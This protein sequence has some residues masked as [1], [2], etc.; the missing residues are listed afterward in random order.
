MCHLCFVLFCHDLCTRALLRVSWWN[1]FVEVPGAWWCWSNSWYEASFC[2]IDCH[3]C[4]TALRERMSECLM[5][6]QVWMR[7][8]VPVIKK[9]SVAVSTTNVTL[10][11]LFG[12]HIICGISKSARNGKWTLCYLQAQ[13]GV[14]EGRGETFLPVSFSSCRELE[15]VLW[16][17]YFV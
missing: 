7:C 2:C 5:P 3:E 13:L 6:T 11:L 4:C 1:R 16:K 12:E 10:L 8:F 14:A 15:F 9:I 17:L